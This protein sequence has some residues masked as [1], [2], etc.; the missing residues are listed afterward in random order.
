MEQQVLAPV[1]PT[2]LRD[3]AR[4]A[5][6][7]AMNGL[8]GIPGRFIGGRERGEQ[9]LAAAEKL[10]GDMQDSHRAGRA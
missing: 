8:S 4:G 3:R 9:L 7:S 2:G 6:S 5:L 1:D 10:V